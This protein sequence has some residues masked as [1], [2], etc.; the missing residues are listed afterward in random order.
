MANGSSNDDVGTW[1]HG[2]LLLT[3]NGGLDHEVGRSLETHLKEGRATIGHANSIH[4]LVATIE[5]HVVS[6]QGQMPRV[7]LNTIHSEDTT[8]LVHNAHSGGFNAICAL[9]SPNVVR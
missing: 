8:D 7:D 6:N 3:V 9:D 1:A 4:C 2:G 5:C